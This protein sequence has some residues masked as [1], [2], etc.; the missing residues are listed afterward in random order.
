MAVTNKAASILTRLKNQAKE[1]NISSQICLQLFAQEEFLR[2]LS[3]SEY[4]DKL[5]LK[6][7]MFI[8]T[9]TE[10]E[11]RPTRDIDFLVK[12]LPNDPAMILKIMSEICSISTENDFINIDVLDTA[13]I[14]LD[15]KISGR[16]NKVYG[17]YQ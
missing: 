5:I 4:K 7:G 9:L 2:R 16:E 13:Q 12:Q 3:A 1:Q 11:S 17:L 10:F 15:K 8:Y 14:T 6:G